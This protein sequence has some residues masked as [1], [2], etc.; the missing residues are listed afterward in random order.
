MEYLRDLP[1]K[2]RMRLALQWLRDNPSESPTIA[3]R[4]HFHEDVPK[5]E[6]SVRVAWHREKKKV[7][8]ANTTNRRV[9]VQHGGHNR[10]LSDA[11]S[12]AVVQ[13]ARDQAEHGLGA[14][15]RM[16]FAAIGH[17]KAQEVPPKPAPSWRWFQK[18]LR[19]N[20]D[21]H[22]IKTKPISKQRVD[23][24]TEADIKAWFE[25]KLRPVIKQ[26]GISH[27]KDIFNMDETGARVGCP[28]GQEVV[29]P[30]HLKELYTSSPE[31]R[32]SVTIIETICADGSEPI[33][34]VVICPG[35]RIM[36][37]WFGDGE[38]F[39]GGELIMT[40]P[41]GYTNEAL[42][43]IWLNHFIQHTKAGPDKPWKLL[44]LDG[45]SSHETPEFVL[46]SLAHNIQ[47][48]QV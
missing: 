48:L 14:T 34:P 40:S 2:Q 12:Q 32:I 18:W 35:V 44:L 26:R 13:Y 28:K 24:H 38:T 42:A 30:K 29:V 17:L 37:S 6:T 41:T 21:L 27:A 45:Q 10:V 33:P 36:E 39:E 7:A 31:N 43:M 23:I 3:A 11:Q 46:T 5:H 47:L 9:V 1:D 22:T 20:E 8:K 4:I 25:D 15:K 16:M 19:A